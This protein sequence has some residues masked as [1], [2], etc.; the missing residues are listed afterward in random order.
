MLFAMPLAISPTAHAQE[1]QKENQQEVFV[2]DAPVLYITSDTHDFDFP[3][4]L[5]EDAITSS[6]LALPFDYANCEV[7]DTETFDT[8]ACCN[9]PPLSISLTRCKL[10]G[11]GF[12]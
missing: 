1:I 4:I 6:Q 8:N 12:T 11:L 2:K 3:M 7:S 5:V 9:S 10:Q